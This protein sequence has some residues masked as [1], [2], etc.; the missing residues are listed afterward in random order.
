MRISQAKAIVEASIDSQTKN[1]NG[2]DAQRP[3]AHL[4]G[5]AGLGKTH[6]GQGIANPIAQILSLAMLLPYSLEE[7]EAASAIEFAV[8]QANGAGLRTGDIFIP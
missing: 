5:G 4:T 2:R 6:A 1:A 8:E 3:I 7:D